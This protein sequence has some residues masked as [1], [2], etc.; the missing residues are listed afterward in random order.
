MSMLSLSFTLRKLMV[1]TPRPWLGTMGGF[2][3]RI[4]AHCVVRKKG[5]TLMSEAPARAPRR[6]FSSLMRSLRIRDLHRLEGDVSIIS[7]MGLWQ[8]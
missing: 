4:R 8:W 6:R 3:W 2:I 1:S 5:W 7:R